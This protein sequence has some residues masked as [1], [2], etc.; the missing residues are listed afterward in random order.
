MLDKIIAF[1]GVFFLLMFVTVGCIF[2]ILGVAQWYSLTTEAQF[3]ASSIGKYG[4]YTDIANNSLQSFCSNVKLNQQQ[5][6][7]TVSNTTSVAPNGSPV[8]AEVSYP[9]NIKIA[10]HDVLVAKIKT[11]CWS[12]SKYLPEEPIQSVSYMNPTYP[13]SQLL[14]KMPEYFNPSIMKL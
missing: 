2:L 12:V 3:I 13:S 10:G 8:W 5:L 1:G 9:Y 14:F 4:G 11:R 6:G 7:V